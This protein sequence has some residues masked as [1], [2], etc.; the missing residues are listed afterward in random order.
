MDPRS[1]DEVMYMFDKDSFRYI[2]GFGKRGQGPGEIANMGY[3]NDID[4]KIYVSDNGKNVIFSYDLDSILYNPQYIPEIKVKIDNVYFPADYQ[5]YNDTLSIARIITMGKTSGFVTSVAKWNMLTG[6]ITPMKYEHPKI[7]RKNSSV[8][9]SLEHDIYVEYYL[10]HDLL[11]I[12]TF[13]GDLKYNIY[14]EDWTDR[15]TSKQY[16]GKVIICNNRILASYVGGNPATG[17]PPTKFHVF[18]IN[19]DYLQ[20]LETG[21]RVMDF[22]YD[23]K[24]N[25][26]LMSLND[27][28]IQF[29]YLD[30][31]GIIG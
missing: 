17:M 21:Y 7:Q 5:Y 18:D 6:E 28:E 13:D 12:C 23:E 25:R 14:G 30:L 31:D 19:G 8:T 10:S 24:N 22:C 2:T 1:M 16:Y 11:S 15:N 20:T 3:V 27:A 4:G 29:A 9:S 26:I